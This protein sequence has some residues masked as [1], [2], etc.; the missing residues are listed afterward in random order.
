M[1]PKLAILDWM[2]PGM[3]SLE[4]CHAVR[5]RHDK[6]Y[7]DI[8]LLTSNVRTEDIIVGLDAGADDYLT[9]PFERNELKARLPT[10]DGAAF[11]ITD[12]C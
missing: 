1:L 11:R 5:K 3:D 7:S 10:S 2:K 9:K 4:I 8:I 6:F 12:S